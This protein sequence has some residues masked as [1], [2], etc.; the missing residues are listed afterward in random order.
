MKKILTLLIAL[1]LGLGVGGGAAYG[2]SQVL[3]PAPA[4]GAHEEK[5]E[6]VETAFI[7]TGALTVPIVTADGD[8]SGYAA[9]ELQL[10][11]PADEVE[12]VGAQMPL[13]LNAINLRTYRTPM[14]AGKD[15]VLPDLDTMAKIVMQASAE[16]VGK[17][18]V[19]RAVVMSAK[20]M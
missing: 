11:V 13:I 2:V 17:G 14:A 15:K 6:K 4:A 1:I 16:A 12:E 19:M 3:G 8:L 9:F 18:K 20:P 10:E 7:P 5:H